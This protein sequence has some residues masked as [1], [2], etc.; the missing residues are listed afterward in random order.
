MAEKV[1]ARRAEEALDFL[2]EKGMDVRLGSDP[3]KHLTREMVLFQMKVYFALLELKRE[4]G[5][6]FMGVQDQLD[7][8][9]HYPATDLTL[10]LLNNRLRPEGDG[11]T[12]VVSTEA[13]DGAALTMQVLKLLNDGEPAGF[14]D[15]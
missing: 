5:L 10:G 1:P 15:L 7:W 6:D 4:F 14:N 2:V 8:I 9:E 12:V 11:Q 13:D 3:V